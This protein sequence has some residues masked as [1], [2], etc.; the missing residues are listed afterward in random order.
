[1]LDEGKDKDWFA[2]TEIVA[3]AVVAAI[4]FLSFLIWELTERHP[5]VDL[6]VFRHRGFSAS[7]LTIGLAFGAFFGNTVL[8][9]LWLQ[10][11][12]GYTATWSGCAS[13]LTGVLAVLAAPVA[14]SM[15]SRFDGRW[16]VFVGVLWMGVVTLARS[17]ATTD[18][19]FW[20]IGIPLLLLGL[21]LP[22]FFVPLTG[23]AL[24]SVD[25]P[26]TA[27]AAGLMNFCRTLS[28]AIATALVNTMWED[29]IKTSHAQLADIVDRSHRYLNALENSGMSL[30]GA[31]SQIDNLVQGQAVM[32]A[33]SQLFAIAGATFVLAAI[34]VW[35]AP[36]PT[37]VAD[38]TLAH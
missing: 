10:N 21:G 9:P 12:M 13:A 28:G 29:R 26:E 38:T 19:T 34:A 17:Y 37:R 16:L 33:T 36:R 4:G 7:V 30:S 14:A 15:A 3:L 24:A 25:E 35:L 11:F 8:T 32:V 2:S 22:F 31:R 5:V 18:M 27:S 6:R 1:M 23:L 20:Q